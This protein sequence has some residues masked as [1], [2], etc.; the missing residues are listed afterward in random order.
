MYKL[1]NGTISVNGS[2]AYVPQQAWILNSSVKD[3]ILFGKELKQSFYDKVLD[4]C[5]LR[6]DLEIMPSG[7]RTEIGEKGIN[8]S[9]GQKSRISLARALYTDADIYLLD[10]PLS[11]VDAHVGKAIFDSVIGPQSMLKEKTRLFVTNSV[12]FLPQ[13]DCILMLV[14]GEVVEM[15]SFDQLKNK[16]GHF[17]EF[18]K[19]DSFN[20]ESQVKSES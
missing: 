3:N 6:P 20:E 4:S 18:I 19:N 15:G 13:I 12:S 10:D 7:D 14:D 9:G 11:S 1:N 5:S 8:L 17:A 2:I 16:N